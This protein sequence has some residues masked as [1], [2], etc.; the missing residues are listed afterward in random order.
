MASLLYVRSVYSLL[1][2]M[3]TIPKI[4][5]KGKELGY[6]AIGLVD[7]NVLSGT[8]AFYNECKKENIKP[9]LGLEVDLILD[10][11]KMSIIL[12]A[13]DD[14]GYINLIK[15]SSLVCTKIDKT[16]NIETLNKYREHN[17]LVLK[18][19][20]MP[21]SIAYLNKE[22]LQVA[23]DKQ[24]EIFGDYLVGFINHDYAGN[25]K[26]DNELRPLLKKNNISIIA[27]SE[28]LY[29]EKEDY[30]EYEVLKCIR[31]KKTL[32][33]TYIIFFK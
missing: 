25:L 6:S 9:I 15:L 8:I 3:L 7:K 24:N 19:D 16:I 17:F 30:E 1:S 13:K 21:L 14:E 27:L 2:S 11:R 23:L 33:N 22:D 10:E 4:V 29:S 5:Q 20:D 31:D 12:Y 32:D 28:S 26:R 18:S